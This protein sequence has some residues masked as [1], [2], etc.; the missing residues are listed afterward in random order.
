MIRCFEV[1][2]LS[3]R[4]KIQNNTKKVAVSP[5]RVIFFA[6]LYMGDLEPHHLRRCDIEELADE[7]K[8][9]RK[10][11]EALTSEFQNKLHLIEQLKDEVKKTD[12]EKEKMIKEKDK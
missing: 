9:L 3:C 10:E 12:D 7:W 8:K 2:V 1:C 11:K 4:E 6:Q 5:T